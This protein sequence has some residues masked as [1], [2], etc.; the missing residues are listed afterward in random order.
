MKTPETHTLPFP[1]YT[2]FGSQ[3]EPGDVLAADDY[4]YGYGMA[5]IGWQRIG[6][7]AG[8]VVIQ[9]DSTVYVRPVVQ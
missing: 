8:S 6:L 2:V 1:T 3:L 9:G 4:F 5:S 7:S